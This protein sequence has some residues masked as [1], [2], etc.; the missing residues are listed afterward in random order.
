[1]SWQAHHWAPVLVIKPDRII[2]LYQHVHVRFYRALSVSDFENSRL[3]ELVSAGMVFPHLGR[4]S[5]QLG[6]PG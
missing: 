5:N 3:L 1:M 2:I 6:F 4:H